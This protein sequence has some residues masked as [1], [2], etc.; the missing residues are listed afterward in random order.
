MSGRNLTQTSFL[1][2]QRSFSSA[3]L[4]SILSFS[5][6]EQAK[7]TL[8]RPA[9]PVNRTITDIQGRSI[10]T[11][12]VSRSL[13]GI[14]ILKLPGNTKHIIPITDLSSEDQQFA[15]LLPITEDTRAALTVP[16]KTKSRQRQLDIA[17]I[18]AINEEISELKAEI[19][20]LPASTI[21]AKSLEKKLLR[22]RNEV[23]EMEN[24]MN[25]LD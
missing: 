20:E 13:D 16:K 23:A 2:V 22:L 12:V 1:Q 4:I 11:Q 25:D 18:D 15:L 3:L 5:G 19:R 9:L 6:C 14:V 8:D 24:E 17:D 7:L 10:D 21:K